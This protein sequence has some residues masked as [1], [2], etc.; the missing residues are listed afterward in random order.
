LP[1][2][3]GELPPADPSAP[4][5]V[6]E[7]PPNELWPIDRVVWELAATGPGAVWHLIREGRMPRPVKYKNGSFWRPEEVRPAI[8]RY[9]TGK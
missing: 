7:A 3:F 8:E 5:F 1:P 4:S 9:R 2:G 6:L